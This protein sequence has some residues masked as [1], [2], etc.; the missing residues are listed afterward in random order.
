MEDFEQYLGNNADE[1]ERRAA[2]QVKEGLAGLRLE[3]KVRA[4]A[5]QR[6]ALQRRRW[7]W[8]LFWVLVALVL[9]AGV[10]F[11]LLSPTA[12][13]D[14]P[15]PTVPSVPAPQAP[16]PAVLPEVPTTVPAPAQQPPPMAQLERLPNPRFAAPE[17]AM[18]RGGQTPDPELKALLDGVWYTDY[19]LTGLLLPEFYNNAH[20]LLQQR[21][22]DAAYLVLDR[23][24]R[25][26]AD[27]FQ[28]RMI[29]RNQQRLR[30]DS[31]ARPIAAMR[32]PN[33]TLLYL[34]AYCMLEMGEG[35]EALINLDQIRDPAS[36]WLPQMSW[37]KGLA[38]LSINQRAEALAV[39]R[40]IA[41]AAKHPYRK[42]AEKAIGLLE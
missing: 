38:L 3:A 36:V 17:P 32:L 12:T 33:D 16:A 10:A 13:P 11:R 2:A 29:R 25:I 34:K 20:Q 40:P 23:L 28:Q 30:E 8:R 15:P 39:L 21:K 42:Q 19:P 1:D 14:A 6:H 35:E 37:Y 7:W 41:A 5:L 4:V 18:V 22:F 31:T 24:E 9:L 26:Q 27:S